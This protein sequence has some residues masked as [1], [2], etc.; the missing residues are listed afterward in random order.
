MHLLSNM[1]RF[2]LGSHH[3][4]LPGGVKAAVEAVRMVVD[5]PVA[6]ADL[7]A[8]IGI[9]EGAAG[10]TLSP[11]T[12]RWV[13]GTRMAIGP[14]GGLAEP[15]AAPGRLPPSLRTSIE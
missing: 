12:M 15:Y 10:R 4:I 11:Q 9:P 3:H 14:A 6:P 5:E 2:R 13:A 8:V 7:A 1:R